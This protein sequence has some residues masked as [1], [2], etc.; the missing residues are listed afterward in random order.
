M[1]CI[2][3]HTHILPRTWPDW[4]T[5][6]GYPGWI[7]LDHLASGN[8]CM[9][10]SDAGGGVTKFREIEPTCWDPSVRLSQMDKA[11]V[12]VQVLSTVP[13]MF[14]YWAKAG[15]A[16]D[17][18]RLLNDH[19]AGV[20]RGSPATSRSGLRRFEGLG[21][22]PMQ[23]PALAC[24]ELERCVKALGLRGVQIGTHVEG[25]NLDEPAIVEVLAH[26]ASLGASV[27]VHP[28]DMLAGE[29]MTRYWTPWLVGMPAES[30]LAIAS[31]I[32]GG[33]F[34]ALPTLRVCVAHGGGS[35]P[36]TVGRL[37]HGRACRP[38]LFP[39]ASRDPREYLA[40]GDVPAR[41]WVDSLVHDPQ[42]LG[43]IV[44]QF[45]ASRVALGSDYPFPLGEESAGL[46]IRSMERELG[47]TKTAA[48]LGG[49]AMSFLGMA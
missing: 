2:D 17:L 30:A 13:V 12:D 29:R 26:A 44:S 38:D 37:S 1:P 24:R 4:T 3:L 8:A 22:V 10:R 20:C 41:F 32:F 28:W 43:L 34:D 46:L 39:L 7:H 16:Y 19:I 49:A 36:A 5:R 47:A 23:D 31:M 14:S 21:T 6:S 33:I 9:C 42:V 48:L 25:K 40:R 45:S 18:S 11:G 35:F 15:D 27:F